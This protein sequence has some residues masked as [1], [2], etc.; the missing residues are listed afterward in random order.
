MLPEQRTSTEYE[1][2]SLSIRPGATQLILLSFFTLIETIGPKYWAKPLLMNAKS[3]FP[4]HG[5]A[6]F[7]TPL[8]KLPKGDVTRD[9]SQRTIFSATQRRNIG[10]ML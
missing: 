9:D 5:P 8:L 10:T 7:E 6:L 3:P 1:P 4:V 2:F